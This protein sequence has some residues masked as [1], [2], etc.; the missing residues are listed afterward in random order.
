MGLKQKYNQELVRFK[1][2]WDYLLRDIPLEEKEKW[3]VEY[4]KIVDTL[5]EL[6]AEIRKG[7]PISNKQAREGFNV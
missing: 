4:T 2:A 6:L 5:N 3:E 7:E 1:K